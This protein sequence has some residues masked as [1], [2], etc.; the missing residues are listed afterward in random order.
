M[1]SKVC[2]FVKTVA[3]IFA[4]QIKNV[5]E[6][7]GFVGSKMYMEVK[8]RRRKAMVKKILLRIKSALELLT[9]LAMA[10]AVVMA[11]CTLIF[12]SIK[13]NNE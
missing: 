5:G 11:L 1:L 7:A 9:S 6:Y 3:G 2:D 8:K 12:K 10:V 13:K 4:P